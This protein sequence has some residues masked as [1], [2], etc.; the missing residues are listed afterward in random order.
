MTLAVTLSGTLH[1]VSALLE[2]GC[3]THS[4]RLLLLE[5]GMEV[6]KGGGGGGGRGKRGA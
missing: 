2:Q 6:E 1:R 4:Q 5:A 3:I